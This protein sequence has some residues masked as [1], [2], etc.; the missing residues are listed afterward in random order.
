[1][2]TDHT[3]VGNSPSLRKLRRD[4]AILAKRHA[5]V[6]IVGEPGTGK[7]LVAQLIHQSTGQKGA[8]QTINALTATDAGL[9][10]LPDAAGRGIRTVLFQ[11]IDE[12]SFLQQAMVQRMI[13]TTHHKPFTR[14]IVTIGE[15]PSLLVHEQ[16]I[17]P[18]LAKTLERFDECTVPSLAKRT[19]D[20]PLLVEHFAQ[21]ACSRMGMHLKSIDIN[22]LEFLAK[23]S[24]KENI[25]ELRSVVEK[26]II[27]SAGESMELPEYLMNERAQLD[28]MITNIA[29]RKA[30]S[31]DQMLA[32]LERSLLHK[33]LDVVAFNRTK[34]AAILD[35]SEANL[36]YRIKKFRLLPP[37]K[38]R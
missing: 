36:R 34:A 21:N 10:S 13:G 5:H 32:N 8:L 37:K 31:F 38:S 25:R 17:I 12:F 14:I 6:L 3:L 1:M 26:G 9:Q 27:G 19:A 29:Q 16:K 18:E 33:A 7:T 30:F 15:K 11:N 28:A 4:I 24:W 35:L 20:I 23:R 2:N 22:T